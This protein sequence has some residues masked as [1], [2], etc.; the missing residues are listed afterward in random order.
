MRPYAPKIAI[1][2]IVAALV[3]LVFV[4]NSA[5]T[6]SEAA[7]QSLPDEVDRLIPVSG[8][9][10]LRQETIGIDVADGYTASLIVNGVA[11][12][13]P[14]QYREGSEELVQDGLVINAE[15]G[16]ITYTPRK[17]GLVERFE[18]GENCVEANVWKADAEPNSGRTV[19]WC[20]SAA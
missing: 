12:T 15:T 5:T 7:S 1:L 6:G 8:G 16:T 20:F 18:T 10:I 9:T 4:A 3:G 17:D 19:N 11:I 14:I 2:A 13:N